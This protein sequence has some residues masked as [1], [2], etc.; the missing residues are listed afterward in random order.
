[1]SEKHE[2]SQ[3]YYLDKCVHL[4]AKINPVVV[5]GMTQACCHKTKPFVASAPLDRVSV[6]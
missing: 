4:I 2:Y 1:M 6:D 5:T 3:C